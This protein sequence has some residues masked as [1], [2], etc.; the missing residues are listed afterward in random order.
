PVMCAAHS[1][2]C[3]VS[4]ANATPREGGPLLAQSARQMLVFHPT[5]RAIE[6]ALSQKPGASS[7][8]CFGIFIVSPQKESYSAVLISTFG[9]WWYLDTR[10]VPVTTCQICQTS[11]K[12][13]FY[14]LFI[15][16]GNNQCEGAI[17][18]RHNKL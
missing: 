4:M 18:D 11:D 17:G 14:Q 16:I 9:V 12:M 6:Q 1:A 5:V 8:R 3:E 13:A 10:K 2:D 15:S 7:M